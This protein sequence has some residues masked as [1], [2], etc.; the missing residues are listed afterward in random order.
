MNIKDQRPAVFTKTACNIWTDPYIQKQMLTEHLNPTSDGAT[1]RQE[2]VLKITD[3]ILAHAKPG[4]SLLDLGCGP[5]IYTSL[6]HQKGFQVTGIDFNKASIEYATRKHTYINY[7]CGDYI[8]NYPNGSFDTV[9]LIYCDMGT[10]SDNDRDILLKNIHQSLHE[11]GV[12]IFDVFT[13]ELI[14]DKTESRNWEYASEGGFWNNEPYLLLSQTFH[15]PIEKAFA[16]QYNLLTRNDNKHFI[17]WDRYYTQKEITEVLKRAGFSKV[18][19]HTD[20]LEGNNFTS[21]NEMFIV[22]EK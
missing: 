20:I 12:L 7:I 21:S 4:G 9:I 14:K 5:G 19:I 15:Y 2:S 18:T 10:H 16:Y 6:F 3:F 11:D 13:E 8:R 22:A 17:V 1:R